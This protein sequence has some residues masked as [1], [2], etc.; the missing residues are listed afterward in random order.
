MDKKP[1]KTLKP[2]SLIP[3][4]LM[5]LAM[6][7]SMTGCQLLSHQ[8]SDNNHRTPVF[9]SQSEAVLFSDDIS[10][11]CTGGYHCEIEHVDHVRLIDPNTHEPVV[12]IKGDAT[13]NPTQAD[14]WADKQANAQV[15]SKTGSEP[16]VK[17]YQFGNSA[18]QHSAKASP[19]DDVSH[20]LYFARTTLGKHQIKVNFY[21]ENNDAYV[22][23]MDIIYDFD[24]SGSYLLHAFANPESNPK[25]RYEAKS[26]LDAAAPQ[27]LCVDII[28]QKKTLKRFCRADTADGI[29]YTD[30]DVN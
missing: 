22:E 23:S 28:H 20:D 25:N 19:S 1:L 11:S 24:K 10:I 14:K 15:P 18:K 6:T 26:L 27:T 17:L 29:E 12:T 16:I 3:L 8:T 4:L 21:P 2:K 9:G 30:T 7:L 5:P 13:T